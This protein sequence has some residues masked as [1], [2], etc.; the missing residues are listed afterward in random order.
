MAILLEGMIISC[1]YVPIKQAEERN[2]K[3]H[4]DNMLECHFLDALAL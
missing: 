3:I 2:I 4:I 1:V